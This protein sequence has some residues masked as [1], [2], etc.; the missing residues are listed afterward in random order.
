[1]SAVSFVIRRKQ[2]FTFLRHSYLKLG[3]RYGGLGQKDR[4]EGGG[5]GEGR[6]VGLGW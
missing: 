5:L 2:H 1:M 3:E 4:L 6:E